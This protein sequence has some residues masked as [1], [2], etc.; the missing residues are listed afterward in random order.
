LQIYKHTA[1]VGDPLAGQ[2]N[3]TGQN[4]GLVHHLGVGLFLVLITGP[5]EYDSQRG[6]NDQNNAKKKFPLKGNIN[7][8]HG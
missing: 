4:S 3:L 7:F 6:D 8:F 5:G 1:A 2:N